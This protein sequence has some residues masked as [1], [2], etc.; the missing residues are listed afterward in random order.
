[1]EHSE[2]RCQCLHGDINNYSGEGN[3]SSNRG[4]AET[5]TNMKTNVWS[6]VTC[7]KKDL[8]TDDNILGYTNLGEG[9][10]TSADDKSVDYIHFF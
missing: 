4:Y 6:G 8:P 10:C 7:Y 2:C 5:A 3:K 1:M 9:Y